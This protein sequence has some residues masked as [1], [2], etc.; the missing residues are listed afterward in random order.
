MSTSLPRPAPRLAGHSDVDPAVDLLEAAGDAPPAEGAPDRGGWG[1]S[2][3]W[4]LHLRVDDPSDRVLVVERDDGTGL[5]A[6]GTARVVAGLPRPGDPAGLLAV[7]DVVAS[8]GP[9]GE[10][11][12]AEV[13]ADLGRWAAD[14][15]AGT[16]VGALSPARSAGAATTAPPSPTTGAS[17]A[18]SEPTAPAAGTS[19]LPEP[20]PLRAVPAP[21]PPAEIA[22]SAPPS[23]GS[24]PRAAAEASPVPT[25]AASTP[26]ASVVATAPAPSASPPPPPASTESPVSPERGGAGPRGDD[27]E[28]AREPVGDEDATGG[29]LRA[30]PPGPGASEP[31]AVIRRPHGQ[32]FTRLRLG[33]YD[34]QQVDEFLDHVDGREAAGRPVAPEE[35]EQ[36]AFRQRRVR[37]YDEFEVDEELDRLVAHLRR[38]R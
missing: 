3:A 26:P 5:L 25:P 10:V 2:A 18:T 7:G 34:V 13:R 23:A 33:G 20:E 11:A 21:E 27:D 24:T 12:A 6:V 1:E 28:A 37:G 4:S 32:R 14:Q 30:A 19:P 29:S 38:P 9:D 31:A 17:P 36:A 35:V 22:T 15:G 16:T 8:P